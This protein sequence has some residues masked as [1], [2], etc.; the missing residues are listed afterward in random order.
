[1][2][3]GRRRELLSWAGESSGRFIIEDDY[4][5]EF[6]FSGQPIPALQGLDNTGC[7]IYMNS[8]TKSLAPSLRISY[9]V[10]PPAL[11]KRYREEL[12]HYAC[13]VS[14]FEQ[15][16]L[17]RFMA[18]GR[19]ER[20]L[21]RLRNAYKDRRDRLITA[22][23]ASSLGPLL[24]IMSADAGLHFLLCVANGMNENELVESAA[25]AGI[26]LAGL[27]AYGSSPNRSD[28]SNRLVIGYAGIAPDRIEK[29]VAM[30]SALWAR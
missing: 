5:S 7:V 29:V 6:R 8:F 27:S 17:A 19:F 13:T 23:Y 20:H 1:M 3:I 15:A 14:N 2:P 26:R 28:F 21:A 25:A 11:L 22:L 9:M 4:D 16:T 30:L 24:D 10:L 12:G 18:E